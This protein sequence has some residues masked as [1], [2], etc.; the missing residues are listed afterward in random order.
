MPKELSSVEDHVLDIVGARRLANESRFKPRGD[1]EPVKSIME[2]VAAILAATFEPLGFR[3]SRSKLQFVR[4]KDS[5][6]QAIRLRGD[7]GNLSGVR[8]ACSIEVLVTSKDFE[9]WSQKVGEKGSDILWAAQLGHIRDGYS[10]LQWDFVDK[11]HRAQAASDMAEKVVAIAV[12]E[13]DLWVDRNAIAQNIHHSLEVPRLDWLLE[14]ALW[15]GGAVCG[16]R[17]LDHAKSKFPS[18]EADIEKL[19]LTFGLHRAA[20]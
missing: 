19:C 17:V 3:Y 18:D 15:A 13:L 11:Q 9:A 1:A 12:S 7:A 20:G 4:K 5:I 16:Q 8:A 14:I 10:H 6:S 2:E